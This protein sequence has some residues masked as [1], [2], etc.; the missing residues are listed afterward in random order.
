MIHTYIKYEQFIMNRNAWCDIIYTT[1]N[2]T[3]FTIDKSYILM[4]T[5]ISSTDNKAWKYSLLIQLWSFGYDRESGFKLW[6][7]GYDRESGFNL[8][9]Y[10]Q[11]SLWANIDNDC[12][13]LHGITV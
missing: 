11:Y 2:K 3:D 13:T 8:S 9:F 6:S 4:K 5:C 12:Q 10:W 1:L 7:F